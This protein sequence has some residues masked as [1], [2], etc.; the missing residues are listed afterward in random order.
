MNHKSF[1]RID[2]H[3]LEM[4][5]FGS[6]PRVRARDAVFAVDN[7]MRQNYAALKARLTS[8]LSPVI[9]VNNDYRGG[10]YTLIHEGRRETLEP[11]SPVF[12]LVKSISHTP[13]GIYV[14]IAPYLKQP[15][16]IEWVRPLEAFGETLKNALRHL[17]AAEFPADARAASARI[18][19]GGI[20]FIAQSVV[21]GRFSIESYERFSAS[22]ADAIKVNMQCA[23]QAQVAGV[24]ALIKRWKAELGDDEWK[25]VYTVVL[26]IWTTSVRNQNTIILRRLMDR[27]NVDTHLIDIATAETPA[28][29]VAVALDNLARI[30]Q[31]NIAAE[32]VFPTDPVLADSLKGTEDLLSNAI[33]KL[34]RCPYSKH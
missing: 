19:E 3:D 30:V 13:L 20:H 31:D 32:M 21:E 27:K 8:H 34:I 12:E 15:E 6:N 9:V 5:A 2:A 16:A 26:S 28:D 14:I 25:K 24:E 11:V 1:S 7:A 29:P 23:A 33:G 17:D 18:L 10:Q 22:V 4:V